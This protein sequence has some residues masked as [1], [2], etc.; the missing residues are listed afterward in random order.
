MRH[1]LLCDDT[2]VQ[3]ER[4]KQLVRQLVGDGAGRGPQFSVA[5]RTGATGGTYPGHCPDGH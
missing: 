3:M 1:I 2:P 5:P 4:L